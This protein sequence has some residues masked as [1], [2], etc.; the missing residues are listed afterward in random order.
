VPYL[1][2]PGRA[3]Q[4]SI[5]PC[6]PACKPRPSAAVA[7]PPTTTCVKNMAAHAGTAGTLISIFLVQFAEGSAPHA[8]RKMRRCAGLNVFPSQ[9][10]V[11][12]TAD[13]AAKRLTR[14]RNWRSRTNLSINPWALPWPSN[15]PLGNQ[16][17]RQKEGFIRSSRGCGQTMN[18]T[19]HREPTGDEVF[20]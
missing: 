3:M 7:G 1:L 5:R 16:K 19:P 11:R 14:R 13:L 9:C 17:P 10:P 12:D 20:E 18:G 4:Y 6:S 2:G 15:R 8:D